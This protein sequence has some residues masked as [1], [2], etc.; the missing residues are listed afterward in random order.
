MGTIGWFALSSVLAALAFA[1]LGLRVA[2]PHHRKVAV[3]L[4][5]LSWIP[6][7]SSIFRHREDLWA[8]REVVEGAIAG[9]L[10]HAG[11]VLGLM[12][13]GYLVRVLFPSEPT[14]VPELS[15]GELAERVEHDLRQLLFL[16]N[17]VDAAV[18]A[19]VTSDLVRR[20]GAELRADDDEVLR[21]MWARFVH[22]SYE[23]D[24]VEAQYRSFTRVNPITETELHARSFLVAYAAYVCE[25]RAGL[26]VTA[27]LG[28]NPTA[29]TVVDE[30]D[31]ARHVPPRTYMA[32]AR[33]TMHPDTL[34]RLNVGRAY[35]KLLED[36]VKE[37]DVFLR[38]KATLYEIEEQASAM[39][40]TL[41]DNPLDYLERVAFDTW[42]PIQRT[43][44]VGLSAI[45]RPATDCFLAR[46][47]LDEATPALEPGDILLMR[48]EWHLSNLGIPGYWTHVALFLGTLD[49]LD[50]R[51]AALPELE[52]ETPSARLARLYP[53]AH[54]AM[55]TKDASGHAPDVVEAVTAGVRVAAFRESAICDSLAA[56]RPARLSLS[57]RW[58]AVEDALAHYGKPY[59][60]N[61]D[62]ATDNGIVCSELVFKA[63]ERCDGLR[64]APSTVSGRLLLSP[65][66]FCEKL[67]AE[68]DGERELDFV[69]FLDG[70]DERTIVERDSTALRA[71][72]RRPKWH[73][74]VA[75]ADGEADPE[76]DLERGGTTGGG[77]D[78][79]PRAQLS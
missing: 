54:R 9:R 43:V 37:E 71:S 75:G 16:L 8:G 48:R 36:R 6:L 62:F 64:L 27:A 76:R 30:G 5:V 78:P 1:A 69:L 23:L 4:W 42:F 7:A 51:F 49:A 45:H 66:A 24:V 2:Y 52:G 15:H 53:D 18:D 33:R 28:A 61:F 3:G 79:A 46:E 21:A 68:W 70:V 58:R 38:T 29:R 57:E 67:D 56:L 17:E 20:A 11:A 32:L 19:I 25:Y 10:P 13:V 65:N 44:T 31:P 74:L 47:R 34:V 60:F 40:E 77:A 73:I 50:A 12:L 39:P 14:V 35:L 59:D 55:A 72:H 41:V 22:G 63:F 26:L